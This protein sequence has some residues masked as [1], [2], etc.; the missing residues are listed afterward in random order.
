M[1]SEA[2]ET[3]FI[4]YQRALENYNELINQPINTQIYENKALV[5]TI[6]AFLF[7]FIKLQDFMGDKLFKALLIRI[8]DY[9]DTMSL[10]DMADR[11]EKMGLIDSADSWLEF[12]QVRNQLTHEYPG[13]TKELIDGIQLALKHFNRIETVLFN[14]KSYIDNKKLI[15]GNP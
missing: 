4:Y 6:D 15:Q 9:K 14:I 10:L 2:L 12:R 3:S 7:R 1:L 11:L 13:N 8:G 5:K